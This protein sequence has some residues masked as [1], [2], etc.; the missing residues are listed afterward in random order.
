MVS[1]EFEEKLKRKVAENFDQSFSIYQAFEDK[2]HLFET[3]TL[4]LAAFIEL[5]HGSQV[6]DVGCGNGISARTLSNA[7]DCN[8]L[9]L[10]LSEKMVAAGRSQCVSEK[11]LLMVGDGEHLSASVGRRIFDCVVYNASIFIFPDVDRSIREAA[12]CLKPGGTIGFSFYPDVQ[13][14]NGDDLLPSLFDRMGEPL[15]K[16][17]VITSYPRV[18]QALERYCGP[19]RHH[20]W[21]WPLD[22]TFLRDF[23]SIPAQ[24]ASLFPGRDLRVRQ[25]FVN[26]LF[27]D[28]K[29][30]AEQ[31]HIVWRL[32]GAKKI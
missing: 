22:E 19:V 26:R 14:S 9:G 27:S 32:A 1:A 25:T 5:Q 3:L 13:D 4:A 10:D 2:Y 6:L 28:M 20:C 24:S 21:Q 16:F 8:V 11:I 18:C 12:A 23:F 17:K 30:I 31:G 7:Y 15:P 29:A